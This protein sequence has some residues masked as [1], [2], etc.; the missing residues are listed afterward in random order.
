MTSR[1]ALAAVTLCA[2]VL[3]P[4]PSHAFDE[5]VGKERI[6]ARAG[7]AIT[8]DGFSDA[9]G[10]GWDFTL[11][12]NER[13]THHF[14]VDLR[15]GAL[16]MGELQLK[17]LDNG[18]VL[19]SGTVEMRIL[20]LTIGPSVG[21]AIGGGFSV[22]ASAGAGVYSVSMVFNGGINNQLTG[23]DTSQQKFGFN[24]G[25]GLSRRL[26]TNW[27]IEANSSAHYFLIDKNTNDIYFAFTNGAD[28]PLILTAS[29]GAV[30]DLR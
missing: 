10:N 7:G 26:S 20:S 6:G 25:V 17:S 13:I 15:L 9:Y 8:S 27:S 5:Y 14:L 18:I 3:L 22:D 11:Y 2:C 28:A 24:G 30:I 1:I 19:P 21:T 29:L 4:V 23:Y 16:S 12:F